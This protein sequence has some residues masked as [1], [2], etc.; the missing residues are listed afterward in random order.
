MSIGE[1]TRR[2]GMG[3]ATSLLLALPATTARTEDAM[4]PQKALHELIETLQRSEAGIREAKA[5]GNETE[6]ALGYL[7]LL[8]S[9]VRSIEVEMV[10]HML[11]H[12]GRVTEAGAAT[13]HCT[14]SAAR[15]GLYG[16]GANRGRY[17]GEY[18]EGLFLHRLSPRRVQSP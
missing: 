12:D 8:R 11:E 3:L 1:R 6:Q 18:C 10:R 4:D 9:L 7:H 5:F 16:A 2:V 13:E 17:Q 15:S 14:W